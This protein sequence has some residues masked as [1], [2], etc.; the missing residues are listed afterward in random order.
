[1][2]VMVEDID[3]IRPIEMRE[4]HLR[5]EELDLLLFEFL[6]ELIYYKD[7]EKLIM[8]VDKISVIR[9]D[10]FSLKAVLKGERI[11]PKRHQTRTDV[12]AV[13]LHRFHLVETDRGW[14]ATV[15]LDI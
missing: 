15:I 8:L 3:S 10:R 13:T 7:S 6:Q 14:D 5:Q 12:K 2:N 1:M 9:D 4:V 11:G